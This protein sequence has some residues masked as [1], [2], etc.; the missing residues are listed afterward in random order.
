MHTPEGDGQFSLLKR[1]AYIVALPLTLLAVL[2]TLALDMRRGQDPFNQMALPVLAAAL[3]ALT[4][5]LYLRAVSTRWIERGF[6]L[7]AVLSFFAKFGFLVARHALPAPD[8]AFETQIAQV[9]IWAPFVYMLGFL[10]FNAREARKRSLLVYGLSVLIGLYTVAVADAES[11]GSF[12]RLIEFYV[13]SGLWIGMLYMLATLRNRLADLQAQFGE[14]ER[15][16]HR[17]VLTGVSN[18][19]QMEAR[20][21]N[22]LEQFQRYGMSWSVILFD[23]D[24]FK[25][26]NDVQGHETGD[27]VLQ[28]VTRLVQYELRTLDQ[29][30]RWG[31]EEFIIL[32]P[33]TD[34]P[35]ARVLAERLRSL[36]A[37]YDFEAVGPVTASFGVAMYRDGE[38]VSELIRRGDETLYKAKHAG[39]NRV[40]VALHGEEALILPQLH[41]PFPVGAPAPDSELCREASSWLEHYGLGPQDAHSRYAFAA[42]FAELAAALHPQASPA[43]LRLTTD[44]YGLMFLH[45]D[46]CD[47]SGIGKD[48]A[49]LHYLS[50]RLLAVFQGAAPTA[51][52]EP[53]AVALAD[54]RQRLCERGSARWFRELTDRMRAY[55]DAL[56]WEAANRVG[57]GVPDLDEYAHMRP[58]TAGLQIDAAFIEVMDGLRLPDAV[59]DHPAVERLAL[60][61]DRAV[62]WSNDILSLEK[63]LQGG[64]VHNLVLVLM[65][66]R[67][68]SVQT[69]LDKAV[70]MYRW[71]VEQFLAGERVLPSFG[72]QEDAQLRRYVQLLKDRLGGILAWSQRSKRYRMSDLSA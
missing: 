6:Y 19:R 63:E 27:H 2:L 18:R 52:D 15:L 25:R 36:L 7:V 21:V 13:A 71:E 53:L 28:E 32:A 3:L 4:L 35:H 44:W 67:G 23:I 42:S 20:L 41:N 66:A 10:I 64:D 26:V 56:A 37:Q 65:R 59:R 45:D 70:E 47:S 34:L 69:A 16:A 51:Q 61:A 68:L 5:A 1:Q 54:V 29:L 62:C 46:R 39:K 43:A 17:D 24:D 22:Q 49:R 72:A 12:T 55:L 31:G 14:M 50:D 48:P 33:Q 60:L 58:I 57:G 11:L 38:S 8:A 9:Y 30:G 40:E